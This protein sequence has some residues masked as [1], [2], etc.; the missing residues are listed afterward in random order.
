MVSTETG[1]DNCALNQIRQGLEAYLD[2]GEWTEIR[3]FQ[4]NPTSRWFNDLD[5]A[6]EYAL[7][8]SK[9]EIVKGVYFVAN[10]IS[11]DRVNKPK[12]K[13]TV[14]EDITRRRWILI[15]VDPDRPTNT[16]ATEKER[17]AGWQ[18]IESVCLDLHN[19][20][21][22]AP[23]LAS[24]GNG[25]HLSYPVD[26]PATEAITAQ[27]K[28]LL[29]GLDKRHGREGKAQVDC[30]VCDLPRIWKIPGTMTRKGPH[31]LERPWRQA[32]L[33]DPEGTPTTEE[34]WEARPTNNAALVATLEDWQAE[35]AKER[36]Q[37][38]R[39]AKALTFQVMPDTNVLERAKK[40]LEAADPAIQ[41][42]NGSG[43]TFKVACRL[44]QGF[45][46]D[47]TTALEAIAQWN[48]RCSPPWSDSE[49]RHKILDA[50]KAPSD[51]PVGYLL[52]STRTVGYL[53]SWI[54]GTGQQQQLS[55]NKV[56][57]HAHT[58]ETD[59]QWETET[60][61]KIRPVPVRWIVRTPDGK[62]F[63]PAG[64]AVISGDPGMGKST[65]IRAV[66]AQITSGQGPFQV[67]GQGDVLIVVAED[68]ESSIVLPHILSCGGDPRRIH[69]LRTTQ[70]GPKGTV[71]P[72][73]EDLLRS[74]LDGHPETKLVV[75]DV[76]ASWASSLGKD[77]NKAQD[78][79]SILD[80]LNKIG[81]DRGMAMAVLHHLT[82]GSGSALNKVSGSQQIA[83]T[84]RCVWIVGE[85][86]NDP[87]IR[88]VASTKGNIPGRSKGFNYR[89][90]LLEGA[91][92]K[93]RALSYGITF[94]G[95]FEPDTFKRLITVDGPV[96]TA[97]EIATGY[98]KTEEPGKSTKGQEC[99][100]W[101]KEVMAEVGEILDKPLKER[102]E[103]AG[104][105][106]GTVFRAK[107]QAKEA[108][109]LRVQ[110][111]NGQW[112]NYFIMAPTIQLDQE[113]SD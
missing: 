96:G 84:A 73:P 44:V 11:K 75:F 31:S 49:L 19:R 15:D 83:A 67:D 35:E 87:D 61:D 64:L 69:C 5:Q 57:P 60:L 13:A 12:G 103:K 1:T 3:T 10:P 37:E 8:Q 14:G 111:I 2:P 18:V 30:K 112:M 23:L 90:E 110:K 72:E 43:Q 77:L 41:G 33:K 78:C 47:P 99:L 76:L 79:R 65:L 63:L 102:A 113:T 58:R 16:N 32:F 62:G 52:D 95:E 97:D 24:S 80:P 55:N 68:D 74:W 26:L 100:S 28:S 20:G 93:E 53:D 70:V 85:N 39:L 108:G 46:L 27:V 21:W 105:S 109:W 36:E 34:R 48:S 50:T 9:R 104:Y 86:P 45:G 42:Q 40:Y 81:Q 17:K 54:D 82:K 66:M 71:R 25:W 6:A 59:W 4:P 51:K 89:E 7:E 22:M 92:V 107:G 98:A 56:S 88:T 106:G 101:L 91:Q 29:A 38:T 94:D